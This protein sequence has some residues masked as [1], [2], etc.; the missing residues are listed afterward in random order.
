VDKITV[1][2]PIYNTIE[3]LDECISSLINQT[4]ENLEIILINDASNHATT[5]RIEKWE[6]KDSRIKV[7]HNSTTVGVGES[8]NIG[9]QL[10]TGKYVYFLDSDDYLREDTLQ[11][12]VDNIG[13]NKVILG[14]LI[15][16]HISNNKET[17]S[18]KEGIVYLKAGDKKLFYNRSVLNCLMDKEFLQE[19]EI[20]FASNVRL[21]S[22]FPFILSLI[23]ELSE[24]PYLEKSIYYKRERNDPISNPSLVQEQEGKVIQDFLSSYN[25]WRNQY[26]DAL[27]TSYLDRHFM[28]FY[29]YFIVPFTT[30]E[31]QVDTIFP[32]LVSAARSVS[33]KWFDKYGVITKRELKVLTKGDIDKYKKVVSSHRKLRHL[34][35]A[36][37]GRTKLYIYLYNSLFTKMPMKK[38]RVVFE[39]FLGKS[40]S[41][42]PK[43]IY[44][45]MLENKMDYQYI[46]IFKEPGKKLPGNAKQ[47]KRFSFQYYYYLATAKYW[48]SNS[49]MPK[50]LNKPKDNI[51][52]QTWH[53]TPLKHLVFDMKDVHSANPMYKKDFYIQ[54]RR[55][56][57]LISPNQYSSDIFR[58]AFKFEKTM[59]EYGYPRNDIMYHSNA[60]EK[61]EEIK[62]SL[63][64][65]LD[66]KVILYAPTWRDDDYFDRGKYRFTLQ[67]D[68]EK[69]K[70]ELSDE[71]VIVLRMH[72]FI[73]NQLDISD[74]KGFAYDCSNYD[75]I[76]ELYLMSD[77]LITD[78]SSVFFDY[79]NLQRPILFYTYDLEKYR[80]TLRG[81]YF[82]L[83]EEA[84]G[85]LLQ[86]SDE[87]LTTI[88]NIDDISEQYRGKYEAFYEKFCSWEDGNA[89]KNVVEQVFHDRND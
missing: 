69:L 73:A 11:L 82:N 47:V 52:L 31:E 89:S 8:R 33:P 30:K 72:Y 65:P 71:Y 7:H 9:L 12:L 19:R 78:Y 50:H 39:S 85:P 58:R 53:G 28:L 35:Q 10:S 26:V 14:N 62:K 16:T 17:E 44:E 84:P 67:L 60:H 6:S 57:Y 46:W 23:K 27:V 42:S 25:Q 18:T 81:F 38:N 22:E 36:L 1:I 34:K 41:D 56:D 68:L 20:R 75:D 32:P 29:K 43:Y 49:R 2:V 15:S 59:L 87:V 55:W 21:F 3:F 66:K 80:D 70:K 45:Y 76:A 79:A 74:Y 5:E 86:T 13:G 61:V 77:I 63:N 24:F 54:S 4:Y 37:S 83:E 40:Y 64:I 48:V 51:Y 88:K